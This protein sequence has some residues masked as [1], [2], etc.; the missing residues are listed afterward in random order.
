MDGQ[1]SEVGWMVGWAVGWG[2]MGTQVGL[3]WIDAWM[4]GQVDGW[5]ISGWVGG[6]LCGDGQL[7]GRRVCGVV[8]LDGWM[9]GGGVGWMDE[10]MG[11][12]QMNGWEDG[13]RNVWGWIDG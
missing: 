13:C 6:R 8:R 1:V 4:N 2:W 10:L 7:V 3:N 11:G 9:A 5:W 12:C